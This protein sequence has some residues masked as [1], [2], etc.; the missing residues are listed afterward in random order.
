MKKILFLYFIIAFNGLLF[1]CDKD[2]NS[3]EIQIYKT[4]KTMATGDNGDDTGTP[5]ED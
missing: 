4:E 3:E 5:D 2:T 1:S